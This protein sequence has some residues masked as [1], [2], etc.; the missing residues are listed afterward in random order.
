MK[1]WKRFGSICRVSFCPAA[2]S[3]EDGR[4]RTRL[5]TD[6]IAVRDAFGDF[7]TNE[8]PS[9]VV[10]A[11]QQGIASTDHC[12]KRSVRWEHRACPPRVDGRRGATLTDLAIVAEV[13]APTSHRYHSWNTQ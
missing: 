1:G 7:F 6:E 8:S 5:T 13:A 10:R 4:M 2:L 12:G 11:P 9:A 3:D